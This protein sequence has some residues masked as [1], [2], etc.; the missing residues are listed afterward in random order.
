[1]LVRQQVGVL[2]HQWI[3]KKENI[4]KRDILGV[5]EFSEWTHN[6]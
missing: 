5:R 6:P 2:E 1:M 3:E 4:A